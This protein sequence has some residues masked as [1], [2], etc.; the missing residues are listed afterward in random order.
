MSEY[1]LLTID[2]LR[3]LLQKVAALFNTC[4]T[5]QKNETITGIKTFSNGI[6]GNLTGNVTGNLSGTADKA[7]KDGSGNTITTTYVNLSGN[8]TISGT[9]TFTGGVDIY[10]A[11]QGQTASLNIRGNYD[12]NEGGQ[13]NFFAPDTGTQYNGFFIDNYRGQLRLIG[14][15]SADGTT[16]TGNG[17]AF[18]LDPYAKTISGGYAFTHEVMV[19]KG[20]TPAAGALSHVMRVDFKNTSGSI[21]HTTYPI[22]IIGNSNTSNAYNSGV[23]LGSVNGTTFLTSG[24]SG[25]TIIAKLGYYDNENCYITSDN[26]IHMYLKCANDSASF[27]GPIT[28]SGTAK[29]GGTSSTTSVKATT[30]IGTVQSS[31]DR[32]LKQDISEFPDALLDA[33]ENARWVQF[34]MKREAPENNAPLHSGM[35]VQELVKALQDKGIDPETYGIVSIGELSQEDPDREYIPDG[36]QWYLCREEALAIE[37]AYQRR[38]A[39]RLEERIK[40]LEAKINK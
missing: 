1:K 13:I 32:R 4:V 2:G 33:W 24:E 36:R 28:F 37:A 22:S 10:S 8:Q 21:T 27:A 29:S 38:R 11:V 31:S 12:A 16:R 19:N 7:L 6:A 34:R 20:D 17:S 40:A 14:L 15:P 26:E 35:I 30:F 3:H 18:Y 25:G 5:K 9:K 23:R 39:D